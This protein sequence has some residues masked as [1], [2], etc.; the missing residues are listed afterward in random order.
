MILIYGVT[1]P[2]LQAG[3]LDVFYP[4]LKAGA[5]DPLSGKMILYEKYSLL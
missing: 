2:G 5:S 1:C 3:D 4:G